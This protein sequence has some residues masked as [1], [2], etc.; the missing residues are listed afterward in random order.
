MMKL[1]PRLAVPQMGWCRLCQVWVDDDHFLL[2][3]GSYLGCGQSDYKLRHHT[4]MPRVG[5]VWFHMSIFFV[6]AHVCQKDGHILIVFSEDKSGL[7]FDT[8]SNFSHFVFSDIGSRLIS[9]YEETPFPD[10]RVV[11]GWSVGELERDKVSKFLRRVIR[12]KVVMLDNPAGN[13]RNAS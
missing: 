4:L 2:P 3:D 11:D 1:H 7:L 9:A 13:L 10:R 6:V 5:D 8:R 12:E